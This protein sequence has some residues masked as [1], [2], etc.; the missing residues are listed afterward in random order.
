MNVNVY[1][2][3]VLSSDP[4]L[5]EVHGPRSLRSI[6]P[7]CRCRC[8]CSSPDVRVLPSSRRSASCALQHPNTHT[9]TPV[10]SRC[11]SAAFPSWT[12]RT[13]P[14]SYLNTDC[15][16]GDGS[17]SMRR[18]WHLR[19]SCCWSQEPISC[20]RPPLL[21]LMFEYLMRWRRKY[22]DTSK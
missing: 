4:S 12:F 10:L 17:S 19:A 3:A 18:G 2:S 1:L 7:R 22:S 14:G 11:R 6:L 20:L 16:T 8:R 21:E 5:C 15:D 9:H 13:G